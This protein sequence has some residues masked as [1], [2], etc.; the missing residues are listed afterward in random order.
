MSPRHRK[1]LLLAAFGA[2]FV[3][4]VL[5][6]LADDTVAYGWVLIV[7]SLALLAGGSGRSEAPSGRR[8]ARAR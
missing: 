2:L 5:L 6:L 4:G 1:L 8:G 3:V 7:A